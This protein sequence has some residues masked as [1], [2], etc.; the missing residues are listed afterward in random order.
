MRRLGS[1][2]PTV[3]VIV[4]MTLTCLG[5]GVPAASIQRHGLYAGE[6]VLGVIGARYV[7]LRCLEYR[8]QRKV[9]SSHHGSSPAT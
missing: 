2:A 5:T 3:W 8:V 9:E 7:A 4:F 6:L 1:L